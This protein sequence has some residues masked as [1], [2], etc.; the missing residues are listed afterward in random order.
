MKNSL[1]F[2]P[3]GYTDTEYQ[4]YVDIWNAYYPDEIY[5]ADEIRHDDEARDKNYRFQRFSVYEY[6]RQKVRK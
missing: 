2:K 3:F 4:A 6:I 1:D 5:A